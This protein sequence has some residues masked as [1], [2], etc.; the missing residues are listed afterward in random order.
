MKALL[1]LLVCTMFLSASC[2]TIKNE[3]PSNTEI[4]LVD[5]DSLLIIT[6]N[7]YK[8]SYTLKIDYG[9]RSVNQEIDVTADAFGGMEYYPLGEKAENVRSVELWQEGV[10]VKKIRLSE[11]LY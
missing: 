2:S 3:V 8:L 5:N 10:Q 6:E 7:A 9:N 1:S 4:Y 11:S